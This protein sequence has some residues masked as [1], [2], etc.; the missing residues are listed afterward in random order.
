MREKRHRIGV[1][2]K[3]VG[4]FALNT[5]TKGSNAINRCRIARA[6]FTRPTAANS[7][8]R[9]SVKDRRGRARATQRKAPPPTAT[10]PAFLY[11][12]QGGISAGNFRIQ[13]DRTLCSFLRARQGSSHNRAKP[14]LG[15]GDPRLMPMRLDA[16]GLCHHFPSGRV[17][18][19]SRNDVLQQQLSLFDRLQQTLP[20]ERPRLQVILIRCGIAGSTGNQ[21]LAAF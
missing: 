15:M 18:W 16:V 10:S 5:G 4:G 20:K 8:Q 12:A 7:R 3:Q 11:I 6:S 1:Q 14:G 19:I 9:S 2:P 17:I 13:A 21:Q